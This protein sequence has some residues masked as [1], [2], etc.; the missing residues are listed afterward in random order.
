MNAVKHLA[1]LAISI[2]VEYILYRFFYW[3]LYSA[4]TVGLYLLMING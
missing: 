2:S 1:K 3:V 4:I